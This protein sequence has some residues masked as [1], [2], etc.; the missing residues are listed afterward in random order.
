MPHLD[1]CFDFAQPNAYRHTNCLAND[2]IIFTLLQV[3]I[4]LFGLLLHLHFSLV[5]NYG[6]LYSLEIMM[7]AVVKDLVSELA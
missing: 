6:F 3:Q 7:C 5:S 4:G 1:L 2:A